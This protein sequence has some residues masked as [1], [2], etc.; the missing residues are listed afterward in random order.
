MGGGSI[1]AFLTSKPTLFTP[2]EAP[3]SAP[4]TLLLKH[5][6]VDRFAREA[7]WETDG[8]VC[9]TGSTT[10]GL[11]YPVLCPPCRGQSTTIH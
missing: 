11:P 9:S 2:W 3:T 10:P 1:P 8:P 5:T 7:S 4:P 6:K